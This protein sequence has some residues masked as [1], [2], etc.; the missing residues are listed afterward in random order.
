M[1]RI[2]AARPLHSGSR[3]A[4]Q[5]PCDMRKEFVAADSM[6]RGICVRRV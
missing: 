6:H 1:V 4:S 3:A 2:D 5:H